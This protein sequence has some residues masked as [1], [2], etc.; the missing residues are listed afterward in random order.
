MTNLTSNPAASRSLG[1]DCISVLR[2]T[3]GWVLGGFVFGSGGAA[4]YLLLG[5]DYFVDVPRWAYI[6][7]YPGFLAGFRFHDWGLSIDASQIVGVLVVGVSY[8]TLA[9]LA[10]FAWFAFQYCHKSKAARPNSR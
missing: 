9:L 5:G 7:F 2:R 10:R 1:T 8:A 4:A 3:L 6:A